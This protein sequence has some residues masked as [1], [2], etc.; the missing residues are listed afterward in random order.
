MLAPFRAV[1]LVGAETLALTST[2]T[3]LPNIPTEGYCTQLTIR[4]TDQPWEWRFESTPGTA[5]FWMATGDI[6]VIPIRDRSQ[7]VDFTF[8]AVS[9]TADTRILYE[10]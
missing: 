2:P 9:A 4:S 3:A 5:Y 1:S 7:L 10:S 8:K 6:F